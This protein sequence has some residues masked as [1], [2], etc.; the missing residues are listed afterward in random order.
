L[1]ALGIFN[2]NI[3]FLRCE[4]LIS[5]CYDLTLHNL[6]VETIKLLTLKLKSIKEDIQ[7]KDETLKADEEKIRKTLLQLFARIMENTEYSSRKG[8]LNT[9]S[10]NIFSSNEIIFKKYYYKFKYIC[11]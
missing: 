9:L 1:R 6:I 2:K 4:K 7:K 5:I 10:G 11:F 3:K 8:I